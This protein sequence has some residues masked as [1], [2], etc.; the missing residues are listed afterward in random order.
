MM[1]VGM[2]VE[3]MNLTMKTKPI[4]KQIPPMA[5][6]DNEADLV[7]QRGNQFGD[8]VV[9]YPELGPDLNTTFDV[10]HDASRL[11][12]HS[13]LQTASHQRGEEADVARSAFGTLLCLRC[14]A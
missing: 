9:E 8:F 3:K 12:N 2:E 10:D 4:G 7:N 11:P 5:S 1:V 14:L 13:G 6:Q